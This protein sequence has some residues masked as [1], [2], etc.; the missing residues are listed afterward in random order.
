MK[1]RHCFIVCLIFSLFQNSMGG[2]K[3]EP[4]KNF[5]LSRY[6]GT[7]YEIA[8]LPASFEKNLIHV[9]ANYSLKNNGKVKV[10]NEGDDANTQKHK[11]AVGKAKIAQ[12]PDVGYLRVSFFGPFYADYIILALDNDYRYAMVASSMHYM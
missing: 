9:T 4:V 7:W 8:R 12:T 2:T 6:L 10:L 5:D 11:K 3:M 1:N